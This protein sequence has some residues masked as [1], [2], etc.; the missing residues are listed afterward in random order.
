MTTQAE[1]PTANHQQLPQ[2]LQEAYSDLPKM[3]I[4]AVSHT[5][6]THRKFKIWNT[7]IREWVTIIRFTVNHF[8]CIWW[9][10]S[11][12][13]SASN[14]SSF[15]W[16]NISL[17][18]QNTF[19]KFHS[20]QCNWWW[21]WFGQLKSEKRSLSKQR[22]QFIQKKWLQRQKFP[23]T[24]KFVVWW[25]NMSFYIPCQVGTLDF[26]YTQVLHTLTGQ[27]F[28]PGSIAEACGSSSSW[29]T[30]I[31]CVCN[32]LSNAV[33]RG[34]SR[35][36]WVGLMSWSWTGYRVRSVCKE[37]VYVLLFGW[38]F[39]LTFTKQISSAKGF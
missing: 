8:C 4:R 2:L 6:D 20:K 7:C 1:I 29:E 12:C 5:L 17:D 39:C 3:C 36:E 27:S 33:L 22:E 18:V 25:R 11:I 13:V 30:W 35:H 37:N 9:N 28:W 26:K 21:L 34:S 24:G 15:A 19:S 31:T 14:I 38:R 10:R 32:L 16:K 23:Q